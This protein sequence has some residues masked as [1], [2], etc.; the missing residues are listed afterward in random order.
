MAAT[1][2]QATYCRNYVE[3]YLRR[4]ILREFIK[5]QNKRSLSIEKYF[6]QATGEV[7]SPRQY[8]KLDEN[9]RDFYSPKINS[10]TIVVCT[11][12]G[13]NGLH[14]NLL[15]LDELDLADKKPVE[16]SRYIPNMGENGELPLT[17]LIS[18]RKFSTGLVQEEI[19]NAHR[20]KLKIRRWNI[21]DVTDACPPERHLPDQPKQN[22]YVND[23]ELK[24]V[25]F[26]EYNELSENEKNKYQEHEMFAG[27][28]TCPLAPT[29]KGRLATKQKSTKTK[30]LKDINYTITRFRDS[31]AEMAK[32]QLLCWKPGSSGLVFPRLSR[33]LHMKTAQ[34][35]AEMITGDR[36]GDD[37]TKADFMKMCA[38]LGLPFFS[39]LDWGFNHDFAVS[40]GILHGSNLFMVEAVCESG[41]ELDQQLEACK[42]KILPWSPVVYPD[43]A[44]PGSIKTFKRHGFDMRHF[45]KDIAEGVE[46]I[47][48]RLSP[49]A[50]KLPEIFFLDGDPGIEK[51]FFQ[52]QRYQFQMDVHGNTTDKPKDKDSDLVDSLRYLCQNLTKFSKIGRTNTS[53]WKESEKESPK[54][55]MNDILSD[56]L[57]QGTN[58]VDVN[59][60]PTKK[61][62]GYDFS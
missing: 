10:I 24:A 18:T 6:H 32:A 11:M 50:N 39:G 1:V 15:V 43:T 31:S 42:E 47:R 26:K 28:A 48:L 35:M 59:R 9:E 21:I 52:C 3:G 38:Q 2:D 36:P 23:D 60:T 19:D 62:V 20:T 4:P 7:I 37:Y 61:K 55:W 45:K 56:L 49:G 12:E 16:E 57:D 29:C 53:K 30:F 13:A 27:C 51:L 54:S 44:Y 33:S 5:T 41:L 17:M 46:A 8:E 25:S 58:T 40:M 22:V 14:A 34:D